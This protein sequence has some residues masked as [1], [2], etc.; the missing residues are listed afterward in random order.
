MDEEIEILKKKHQQEKDKLLEKHKKQL[1]SISQKVRK[2]KV[3]ENNIKRKSLTR[4]D[5]IV[6]A[7]VRSAVSENKYLNFINQVVDERDRSFTI[8]RYNEW[9]SDGNRPSQSW[10][11]AKE[12][13]PQPDLSGLQEKPQ[14]SGDYTSEL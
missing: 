10:Q 1:A 6:G 5:I 14:Q 12:I 7:L 8:E 13:M 9:L 4:L 11:L 2:R 3:R